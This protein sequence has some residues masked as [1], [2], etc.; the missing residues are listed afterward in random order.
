[1]TRPGRACA[2]AQFHQGLAAHSNMFEVDEDS[3]PNKILDIYVHLRCVL[4][5]W[6]S[7]SYEFGGFL[8]VNNSINVEKTAIPTVSTYSNIKLLKQRGVSCCHTEGPTEIA[9]AQK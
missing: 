3:R 6:I 4:F 7:I 9:Y 5:T 1:M 8:S 2:S